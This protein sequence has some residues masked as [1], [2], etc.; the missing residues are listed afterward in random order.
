MNLAVDRSFAVLGGRNTNG[1]PGWVGRLDFDYANPVNSTFTHWSNLVVPAADGVSVSP[2][3][4]RCAVTSTATSLSAPSELKIVDVLTGQALQTVTL[5]SMWNAY[6]T[7]WQDQ[8]SVA[9]Y[10][11][12]GAGCAGSAGVP[13]LAPAA[14]SRPALGGVLQLQLSGLPT[15]G[16]LVATGLSATTTSSGL[17]LPLDLSALG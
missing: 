2:E 9:G 6:T 11:A 10:Q 16:A 17:P 1:Q 4:Q 14:G 12:F 13:T 7:A 3:G 8:A 15:G 5:S